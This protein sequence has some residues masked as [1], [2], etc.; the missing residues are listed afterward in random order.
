M[1]QLSIDLE[2]FEFY[3]VV[4]ETVDYFKKIADLKGLKL[5]TMIAENVPQCVNSD[6][7]RIKQILANLLNNS[8]KYTLQGGI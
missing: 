2:T 3:T 4:Y 7:E 8:I 1:G 5:E 6:Q